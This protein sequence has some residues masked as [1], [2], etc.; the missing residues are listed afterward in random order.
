M[1]VL[2]PQALKPHHYIYKLDP[3]SGTNAM[4]PSNLPHTAT[5]NKKAPKSQT[6]GK[7]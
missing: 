6:I 1:N 2:N 3:F 4:M 5:V 7:P